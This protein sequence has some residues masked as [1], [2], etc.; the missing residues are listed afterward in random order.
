MHARTSRKSSCKRGVVL[1]GISGFFSTALPLNEVS[2]K[3]RE[4]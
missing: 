1:G 2:E 4:F 3:S